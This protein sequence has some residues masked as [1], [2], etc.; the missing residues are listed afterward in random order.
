V[1][2]YRQEINGGYLYGWTE[3]V[4]GLAPASGRGPQV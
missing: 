4:G 3:E 1:G 2:K